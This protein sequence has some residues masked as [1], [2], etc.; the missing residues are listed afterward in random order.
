MSLTTGFDIGFAVA[1]GVAAVAL[2]AEE[3]RGIAEGRRTAFTDRE[4]ELVASL[5]EALTATQ[6]Q[7]S[8]RLADWKRDL[9]RAADATKERLAEIAVRQRQLLGDVSARIEA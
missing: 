5:T 4:R 7:V 6:S 9:D 8:Q 3:E 2:L 1:V